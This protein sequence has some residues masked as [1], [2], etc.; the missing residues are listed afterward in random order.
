VHPGLQRLYAYPFERMARLLDGVTPTA[1]LPPLDLGVGRPRRS[2]PPQLTT[3]LTQATEGLRQYPATR[4]T[5][6]LRSACTQWADARFVLGGRLDAARHVLPVNGTREALFAIAQVA[7]TP[8]GEQIAV[9]PNPFY[10]I[11]E[12][13]SLLAGAEPVYVTWPP[14]T[15]AGAWDAVSEATWARCAICYVCSP[16]N[17]TGAVLDQT[18]WEA[19]FA[20]ADRHDFLIASDE[21]YSELYPDERTPPVGALQACVRAGRDDFRRVLVFQSLSKRSNAPGL[22]SGFV[23]GDADWIASFL[24]YRT[25][26]GGAMS[27]LVQ[28][29]SIAAWQDEAHVRD[30][31]QAYRDGFAAMA[32][33]L[34]PQWRVEQPPGAFYLWLPAPE[35]DEAFA[36]RLWRDWHVRVLPGSYL[37]RASGAG[38][39]GAHRVRVSVVG[40]PAEMQEAGRRLRL[41]AE[42]ARAQA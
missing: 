42:A 24:R 14:E 34:A 3:A 28:S 38:N 23:A 16:H 33:A 30:N 1:A 6:A 18:E 13:A 4:G 40:T 15:A 32:S 10:Q 26:Q 39:P 9:L 17:P 7:V 41:A 20:L 27:P 21:C 31:R 29:A 8:G 37:G 2:P 35:E 36:V 5:P 25:Y 11:Y 12:G 22:R 19:L